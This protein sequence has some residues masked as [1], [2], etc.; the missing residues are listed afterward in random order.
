MALS[1]RLVPQSG[2]GKFVKLD[3][4]DGSRLVV[5]AKATTK[6]RDTGLRAIRDLWREAVRGSRGLQGHG[7]G[8]RPACAFELEGEALILLRLD[9]Y[10]A[11]ATGEIERYIQADKGQQRRNKALRPAWED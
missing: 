9:D 11:L 8:A 4:V 10:A 6:I 2:G 5:S 1:G 3:Q 7:D